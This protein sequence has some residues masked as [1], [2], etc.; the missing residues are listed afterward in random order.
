MDNHTSEDG[1]SQL[2]VVAWT[3]CGNDESNA[4]VIDETSHRH[5][6]PWSCETNL[7][8]STS[9]IGV[10]QRMNPPP[11]PPLMS[12]PPLPSSMPHTHLY[13][14]KSAYRR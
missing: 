13:I 14:F 11:P 4:L 7:N 12:L 2:G 1:G 8:S 5:H 10:V 9:K 3:E 6:S